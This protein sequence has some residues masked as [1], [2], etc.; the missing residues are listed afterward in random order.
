MRGCVDVYSSW[1]STWKQAQDLNHRLM[2]DT[3]EGT[4]QK[5]QAEEEEAKGRNLEVC[6]ETLRRQS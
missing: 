2:V 4:G 5:S 6:T 1:G 3:R